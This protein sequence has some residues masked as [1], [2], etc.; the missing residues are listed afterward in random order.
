MKKQMKISRII[1]VMS[2]YKHLDIL[3]EELKFIS[4]E[5]IEK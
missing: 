3:L 1:G 2:I 5:K 4:C